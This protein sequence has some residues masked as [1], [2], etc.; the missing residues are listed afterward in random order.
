M[1]NHALTIVVLSCAACGPLPVDEVDET[2]EGEVVTSIFRDRNLKR[3]TLQN[4]SASSGFFEVRTEDELVAAL[5][6]R[7]VTSD[8]QLAASYGR[9]I[10]ITAP[11]QLHAPIIIDGSL[12]GVTIESNGQVQIT[13]LVDGIDCFVIR[14]S[15]PTLRGL[16]IVSDVAGGIYFNRA[17]VFDTANFDAGE[18]GH[19]ENN[20]VVAHA[21]I[22]D[23]V[24][25]RGR[26][27]IRD[28][29]FVGIL[30]AGAHAI[31]LDGTQWSISGNNIFTT[32][33]GDA[34]HMGANGGTSSINGNTLNS[35]TINTS[36]STGLNSILGNTECGT[37]TFA[38]TDAVGLNT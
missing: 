27:F 10:V 24:G 25:G 9:R 34:I 28:N 22:V 32:G 3:A 20:L 31:D 11:I 21:F 29:G 16:R 23:E 37:I 8:A 30:P 36:L 4:Q 1:T 26:G 14:G 15:Y 5:T 35:G 12:P 33:G 18:F 2:A 6:P 38:A 17:I 19:Y 7:D 13:P